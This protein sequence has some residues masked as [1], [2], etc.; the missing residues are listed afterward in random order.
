MENTPSGN[1][2]LLFLYFSV[3]HYIL[4]VYHRI[5]IKHFLV[6]KWQNGEHFKCSENY[7]KELFL[8]FSLH[9]CQRDFKTATFNYLSLFR[10]S[11]LHCSTAL[12]TWGQHFFYSSPKLCFRERSNF[13]DEPQ[14]LNHKA[15]SIL[16]GY[17]Y[18]FSLAD[19]DLGALLLHQLTS[20]IE[21]WP[22]FSTFPTVTPH[23]PDPIN[24]KLVLILLCSV[25]QYSAVTASSKIP[26]TPQGCN[27]PHRK[28]R[29]PI[30]PL[31]KALTKSHYVAILLNIS[32]KS[33]IPKWQQFRK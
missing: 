24:W 27:Y 32:S 25:H 29:N 17:L 18:D 23:N 26:S 12:T 2:G 6:V 30:E 14:L 15:E 28:P 1:H 21:T 8:C 31:T 22:S 33:R 4:F 9:L 7:W 13:Q 3:L 16:L 20:C 10:N 5:S 19:L 11:F